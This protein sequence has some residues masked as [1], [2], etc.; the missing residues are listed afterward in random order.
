MARPNLPLLLSPEQRAA[1]TKPSGPSA[2]PF[3]EGHSASVPCLAGR[4]RPGRQHRPL[5]QRGRTGGRHPDLSGEVN[6]KPT[7]WEWRA[8]GKTLTS[9]W[10]D[11]TGRSVL[12][13]VCLYIHRLRVNWRCRY[14][15]CANSPDPIHRYI[16]KYS[17]V[18]TRHSI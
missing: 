5:Y 9:T 12:Q 8:E 3:A 6:F 7:R 17:C 14:L 16:G 15:K 18:Q 10:N 4:R 2:P 1:Q 11:R 13:A